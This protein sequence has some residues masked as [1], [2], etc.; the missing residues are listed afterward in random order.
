M[1]CQMP[2]DAKTN[3]AICAIKRSGVGGTGF[4]KSGIDI[5]FVEMSRTSFMFLQM[6]ACSETHGAGITSEIP[7]KQMNL[8]MTVQN[9]GCG[10]TSFASVAH[11]FAIRSRRSGMIGT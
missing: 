3:F 10:K 11:V 6:S 9:S 2:M 1:L 4:S 5:H 7:F 8:L